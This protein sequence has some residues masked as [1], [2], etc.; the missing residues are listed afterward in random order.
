MAWGA[1]REGGHW[2][3]RDGVRWAGR[4][5]IEGAKTA[6]AGGAATTSIRRQPSTHL[7]LGGEIGA[8]LREAN[9]R[10]E[11]TIRRRTVQRSPTL[12]A[13]GDRRIGG[14]HGARAAHVELAG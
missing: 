2:P 3:V 14:K 11:L 7:V 13:D 8:L 5:V 6:R 4:G 9:S 12:R 10:S 1:H